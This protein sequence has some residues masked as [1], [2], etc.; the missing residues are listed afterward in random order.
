MKSIT[1]ILSIF[2]LLGG[3]YNGIEKT[4]DFILARFSYNT[5]NCDEGNILWLGDSISFIGD[6]NNGLDTKVCNPSVPGYTIQAI[7]DIVQNY[8]EKNPKQIFTMIGANNQRDTVEEFTAHY[9]QLLITL[10]VK[11]VPV[12]CVSITP[13]NS[14][15]PG[16]NE[17]RI[18]FNGKIQELCVKYGATYIQVNGI[19]D[20]EYIDDQHLKESGL[21]NVYDAALPY[22]LK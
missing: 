18:L 6:F 11:G 12:F 4:T 21:K 10:T 22:V 16:E 7:L 19:T 20:D 8:L 3:C 2:I 14:L 13:K 1:L 5:A 17:K 9:E 15:H